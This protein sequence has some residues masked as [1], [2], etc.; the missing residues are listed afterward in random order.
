MK[1]RIRGHVPPT[2]APALQQSRLRSFDGTDLAVQTAGEGGPLIVLANG[3]GGSMVAW[4]ALVVGLAP[5]YRIVSWDYRGLYGSGPP[6]RA[7]AIRIEDHCRDLEVLLDHLDGGPATLIGWSMGV[8]VALEFALSHPDRTAGLVLV[9]GAPGDPFA[10]VLHTTLSRRWVPA[11]CRV[12]EAAPGSFGTVVR[13][14]AAFGPT[15]DLLRRAKVVAPSCDLAVFRELAAD[16]AGLDWSLYFRTMRAMGDHSAWDR[17]G[18]VRAPAL[19]VGGTRD[20]F[21]PA[22]VATRTAAAIPHARAVVLEGASHY[23]PLEFPERLTREIE[24]FLS[25]HLGSGGRGASAEE[26]ARGGGRH[27]VEPV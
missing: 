5:R 16:F 10:G 27:V 18:D 3:L 26:K 15:P 23:A 12:V 21:T 22:E 2:G 13:A 19:V 17:L 20:L 8:Q 14:L 11:A 25:E 9:C 4:R 7:D 24:R 6:P 1:S